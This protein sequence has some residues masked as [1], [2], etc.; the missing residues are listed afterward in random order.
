MVS[1]GAGREAARSIECLLAPS[2]EEAVGVED[3][4]VAD[5]MCGRVAAP[6]FPCWLASVD[7]G[8]SAGVEDVVESKPPAVVPLESEANKMRLLPG[9]V[10]I[11]ES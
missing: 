5:A 6:S 9:L 2:V 11:S 1:V 10:V 8:V 7:E 3:M 4:L